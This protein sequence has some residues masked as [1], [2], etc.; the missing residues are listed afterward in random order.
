MLMQAEDGFFVGTVLLEVVQ[1]T[2]SHCFSGDDL[3]SDL[4]GITAQ[5]FF[6]IRN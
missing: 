4:T 2:D 6:S 5:S 1:K 3:S